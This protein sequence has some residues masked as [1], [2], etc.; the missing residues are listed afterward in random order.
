MSQDVVTQVVA[1]IGAFTGAAALVLGI[2]N[3]WRDRGSLKVELAENVIITGMP[4]YPQHRRW[5]VV[6]VANRGRRPIW[7]SSVSLILSTGEQAFLFDSRPAKLDEGSEPA[8][9]VFDKSDLDE[10]GFRILCARATDSLGRKRY[11]RMSLFNRMHVTVLRLRN[12]I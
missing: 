10:R 4:A 3:Y 9:A 11:S 1:Q 2:M 7:F 5:G 12:K 6:Y 8:R